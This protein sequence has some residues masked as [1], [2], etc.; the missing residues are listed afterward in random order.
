MTYYGVSYLPPTSSSSTFDSSSFNRANEALTYQTAL[1]N[2]LAYPT[3]QGTEN[4]KT[5]NVGGVLTLTNDLIIN[6]PTGA[7]ANYIQFTDGSK[8]STAFVEAN[9]AQLNSNN[10]FLQPFTNTFEGN[11]SS[12]A[13]IAPLVISNSQTSNKASL[14]I[15]DANNLDATLY[16]NQ[17][18]G[19]LTI[20]NAGGNS[21]TVAPL[22]PNNTATFAN[23]ISCGAFALSAGAINGSQLTLT[24]GAN[25]SVLTTTATGLNVADP[26]VS[27]GNITG[28]GLTIATTGNDPY[29]IESR[30]TQG[31]GLT[32]INSTGNN[33]ELALSNGGSSVASIT[34]TNANALDFGASSITTTGNI[35]GNQL[36]ITS[37]GYSSTLTTSST[38]LNTTDSIVT[39]NDLKAGSIVQATTLLTSQTGDLYV[40]GESTFART[41]NLGATTFVP[42]SNGLYIGRNVTNSSNEFDIVAVN[43]TTAVALNIYS[44]QNTNITSTT[45]PTISIANNTAYL[46][47]SQIATTSQIVGSYTVGQII[48][49]I[50]SS[51][52]TNFLLCNGQQILTSSYPQ[53]F[54]LIGTAY[55]AYY[56][57]VP[58]GYYALPNLSS[59]RFPLGSSTTITLNGKT[60]PSYTDASNPNTAQGGNNFASNV[61]AHSHSITTNSHSHGYGTGYSN[62]AVGSNSG[63]CATQTGGTFP[64]YYTQSV[65]VGGGTDIAGGNN[66][67]N[68]SQFLA[69]NYYIY[70]G[71]A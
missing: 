52:P 54:A 6:G 35:T 50:F 36:I 49:G 26:I 15:D 29:T 60:I 2:F 5:T 55:N 19:G 65:A 62:V 12:S 22:A 56:S 21:F 53:L 41:S 27:T 30:S 46:N 31:Y 64:Y 71:T 61:F 8:Q 1:D 34:C 48:T 66:I 57:N 13:L 7:S 69:V 14:Y 68:L 38:G 4:L 63:T 24:S 23:P 42:S 70:A 32:I 16:S 28:T 43:S 37:G 40:G 11:N 10:L 58:S 51:P 47:G 3:A 25:T 67:S 33:A 45:I 9:Y 39:T 18:D 59:G 44:T 20:R 17:T